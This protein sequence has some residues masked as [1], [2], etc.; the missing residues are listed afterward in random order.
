M[1]VLYICHLVETSKGKKNVD[2]SGMIPTKVLRDSGQV[3]SPKLGVTGIIYL[4]TF[5]QSPCSSDFW[6]P[7]VGSFQV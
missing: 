2:L 5:E 4:V 6:F 3:K 1:K 7:Y